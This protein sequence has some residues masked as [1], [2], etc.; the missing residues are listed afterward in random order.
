M[1]R[2]PRIWLVAVVS[3]SLSLLINSSIILYSF[4][5]PKAEFQISEFCHTFDHYLNVLWQS[6]ITS[7]RKISSIFNSI[8]D[9]YDERYLISYIQHQWQY[10]N[11]PKG[12]DVANAPVLTFIT[13]D[14]DC[15]DFARLATYIFHRHGYEDTY[16]V[17]LMRVNKEP[18]HAI[19]VSYDPAHGV[20]TAAD[21]DA[22]MGIKIGSFDMKSSIAQLLR[23]LYPEY[24][25][26]SVRSWNVGRVLWLDKIRED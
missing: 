3:L 5:N 23:D 6:P 17:S 12:W 11:D 13:M 10:K 22:N 19:S 24:D 18:G 26:Y 16:F 2:P 21:I 9:A 20:L 4:S 1:R 15:D 7:D 14:G 25:Y 8:V